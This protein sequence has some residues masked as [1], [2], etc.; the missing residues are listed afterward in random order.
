MGTLKLKGV[1]L[2]L[3]LVACSTRAPSRAVVRPA[4]APR[5]DIPD[6]VVRV[7]LASADRRVSGTGDFD[8][9]DDAGKLLA[10]A[11]RGETW[12]LEREPAGVRIRAVASETIATPWLRALVARPSSGMLSL[13]GKRFRGEFL[14]LPVD[15]SLMVVNRLMVEDYLRGVVPMEIGKLGARDSA[16]VQAQAVAARSYT[17][18]RLSDPTPR[19]FDLRPSTADQ[20]YGGMAAETDVANDAIDATRGMVIRWQGRVVDA[21]FYSTCGG[22]SAS[23]S[24]VWNGT[25]ASYLRTVSDQV[26]N[27][28]RFYCEGAA[29]YRW[30]RSLTA[31]QLN[32]ALAQ[33]LKNFASVPAGGPG[34]ARGISVQNRGPS[35]RVVSIAIET[36]RGVFPVR[37]DDIRSV[38]RVAGGEPLSSTYFSVAP[39]F[40]RNGLVSSLTLRGQGYGHGVGMC[41]WG[42]IG[43]ARAGQS[44]REILGTYYPGTTVGSVQ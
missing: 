6:K 35:G 2:A 11:K 36:D 23:A 19:A 40:D 8:W 17:F 13:G 33:Y 29:R 18:V 16:A 32:T 37:G 42:A 15:T 28:G 21:P 14:A 5:R 12:R 25:A 20:V 3:A 43:R 9:F 39:E 24:E 10:S 26:G 30:T 22:T 44:F 1:W 34:I 38:L 31:M 7:V 27:S 4:D 41:Q